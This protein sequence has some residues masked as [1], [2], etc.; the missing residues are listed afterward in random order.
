M[1]ELGYGDNY[2]YAHDYEN[3]FVAHEFLPKEIVGT[4]L[5][6]TGNNAKENQ[7]KVYLKSLW[8]DKYDF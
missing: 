5:Y 2:P 1:K 3:A 8:K 4:T 6:K 7:L